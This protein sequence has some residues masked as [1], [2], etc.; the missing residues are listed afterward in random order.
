ME[1][2]NEVNFVTFFWIAWDHKYLVLA[3]SLICGVIATVLALTA[4]PMFKAQVVVTEVH[5]TGMSAGGGLMGQ[6]GGL[7]SI[8]GLNLNSNGQEPERT[9]ILASRGLVENFIRR[10]GLAR[11]MNGETKNPDSVWEAVEKFRNLVL[12]IHED[13]LKGTTTVTIEWRDPAVAARWANDF[14]GL[15]NDLL[16]TRAIDE[17]TR[18]IDY[19]SKE[20]SHTTVIEIQHAISALIEN[21]TK[22]LM[23]AHGRLEYGFTIV[24][25]A[26]PPEHRFSPRR[27][28]MVISGL[29]IG[30]FLGSLVAWARKSLRR[31]P[32]VATT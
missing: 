27:T 16:R 18:N 10:Y 3:I 20:F 6:L 26:V 22:K 7:A 5:D 11:L 4:V 8:A 19:L 13:K 17:S 31:R 28:L 29:I 32:S 24:D 12:D 1:K 14:V 23:L 15:A 21:E 2:E 9:A 25:P 30:G